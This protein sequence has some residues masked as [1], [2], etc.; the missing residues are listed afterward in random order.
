MLRT[1]ALVALLTLLVGMTRADE[2]PLIPRQILFGNP[3]KTAPQ[4]SPDGT[5]LAYLAP[6]DKNVLQV[7]VQTTGKDDAKPYTAAPKRGVRVF[8]WTSATYTFIYLQDKDGDENFHVYSVNLGSGVIRELTPFPGARDTPTGTDRH[9]P[10]ELLVGLNKDN[11]RV[12][13]VYR[14][15]LTT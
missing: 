15:D 10:N 14:I 8:L 3:A 13:D 1:L 6:D 2:P 11:P 12:F 4:I 9:F 7:W 5:R